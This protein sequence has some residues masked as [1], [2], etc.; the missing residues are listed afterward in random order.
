[1]VGAIDLV[2]NMK[3]RWYTEDQN[4]RK[5]RQGVDSHLLNLEHLFCKS[6]LG[7]A[8][9]QLLNYIS[10]LMTVETIER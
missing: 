6:I 4:I 2:L 7:M 3:Y 5:T 9:I 10:W 8:A 1:M